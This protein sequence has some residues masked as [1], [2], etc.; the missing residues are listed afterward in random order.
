MSTFLQMNGLMPDTSMYGRMVFKGGGNT[1]TTQ[2]GVPDWAKPYLESAAGDAQSLYKSG[3]LENVAGQTAD[4]E[5]AQARIRNQATGVPSAATDVLANQAA[6]EGVFGAD[7]YGQVAN[8]LQPQI[9]RQIQGALGQQAGGFS[10]S[11]NLGGARAQAASASAAGDIASRLA[12]QEVAAQ[13][14]GAAQGAQGLLGAQGQQ[15]GQEAAAN[16]A[17]AASGQAQQQ[18]AQNQAD[19]QYQGIQRLFGLINPGTVGQQQTTTGG[20][21]K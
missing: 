21:G 8:Q 4:Q 12:S 3:A 17:L 11:G 18:Q 5:A 16:Q 9:D 20:G 13:R 6:G 10:R 1:Q 2:S 15:F 14:A 7:A 19:A